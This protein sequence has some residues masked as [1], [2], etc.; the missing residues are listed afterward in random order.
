MNQLIVEQAVAAVE[1][2]RRQPGGVK[3]HMAQARSQVMHALRQNGVQV[4]KDEVEIALEHEMTRQGDPNTVTASGGVGGSAGG[5]G[6]YL[7][8]R[9]FRGTVSAPYTPSKGTSSVVVV[10]LTKHKPLGD[11][12]P[13]PKP[14]GDKLPV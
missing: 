3:E 13:T 4:N 1:A 10:P 7:A 5:T 14:L 11:L 8:Q 6:G 2:A 9:W 12:L